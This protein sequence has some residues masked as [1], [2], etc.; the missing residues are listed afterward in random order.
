MRGFWG[1]ATRGN[2]A[3]RKPYVPWSECVDVTKSGNIV[4]VAGCTYRNGCV[5]VM[6][7]SE[8]RLEGVCIGRA[9]EQL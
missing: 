7:V 5:G 3:K 6:L 4:D 1:L 8:N 2:W 9:V